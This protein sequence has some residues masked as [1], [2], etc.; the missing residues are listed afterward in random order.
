MGA[1]QPLGFVGM[2]KDITEHRQQEALQRWEAEHDPLTGLLN[3]RGFE[4]RLEEALAEH[5]KT[6][7]P[8]VLI[9]FD[10]DYFKPINDEGGHA[11]GDEMLRRV[12]QVVA[13]EVRRSDHVAR[14]GGDEFA[15]LLPSCTLKQANEI[16]ESLRHAVSEVTVTHAGKTFGITLSLGITVLDEGDDS[17]DAV[18]ERA[19]LASYQAKAEGRN[20]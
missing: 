11:L 3:R 18:L 13:W 4:R 15:V 16:A 14:Q 20:R 1:D 9:L 6:G 19:D 12:A 2:V 8:A 7:T 10:L 5:A 17:I